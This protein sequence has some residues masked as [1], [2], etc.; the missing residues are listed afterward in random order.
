MFKL[1]E[2][3][4]MN[5]DAGQIVFQQCKNKKKTFIVTSRV[6]LNRLGVSQF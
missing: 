3:M 6:V 1:K 5:F 2:K 4:I